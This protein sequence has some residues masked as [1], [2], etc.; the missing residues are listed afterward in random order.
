MTQP[1]LDSSWRTDLPAR[2]VY[3]EGAGI[4]R[5]VPQAVRVVESADE[6]P[7][8]VREARE[9]G[10][11]IIPRGSGSGMPGGAVGDGSILDLSRLDWIASVDVE[12]RRV[13]AGAGAVRRA[14]D[15]AARAQGLRFPVDPSSG[16]FCTVGGMASTNAA[17]PHTLRFGSMRY[18]VAALDCVFDDGTRAVLRRGEPLPSGVPAIER[19]LADARDAILA[20]PRHLLEHAGVR[21]ESSG[22]G[23]ADFARSGDLIDLLVGSEGT[24]VIVVAVELALA[25]LP[26]ATSSVLAEF[27]TL[28]EA[29]DG[30]VRARESGASAC[31]LLDRTFLDVAARGGSGTSIAPSTEAVLL[32]EVEG[33]DEDAA[34]QAARA[35]GKTFEDTGATSVR[36]AI[37]RAMEHELWS[38]RHAAS[39]TLARLDPELKSMQFVEDGAVPPERLPEYVR[40]VRAALERHGLRGVIFGHAGDAHAHVNPLID[41]RLPDWR[42][43]VTAL[44]DDVVSL[45]AQLGGTLA[46]EH[47]DGRLRTPLLERVWPAETLALFALVKR[48]FD[49]TSIFN[50]GVKVPLAGQHA[51]G[52]I[53]YDPSLPPLPAAARAALDNV[54]RAR[55]YAT[56]RLALLEAEQGAQR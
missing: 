28:E 39:P 30:A 5:V 27:D 6:V 16:A 54:E 19:F 20:A 56:P 29:V 22:Y 25:P 31:E 37:D 26:G 7:G 40:G 23:L 15:A 24:L 13:W 52:A 44:L 42:E 50:P 4:A 14:V 53:K 55:A 47:G 32:A 48:A 34:A 8:I 41:V 45:T 49:P 43:R 1:D 18:W 33:D 10:R 17:G 46:G 9:S 35:L 36:L 2:A 11:P 3:S 51:L 21:K 12:R 38:L